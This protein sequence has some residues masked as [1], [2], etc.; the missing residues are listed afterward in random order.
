MGYDPE[1]NARMQETQ[2][3]AGKNYAISLLAGL[4]SAFVLGKIISVMT[5]DRALHGVKVGFAM[6]AILAVWPR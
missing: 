2:M 1:D 6:G 4:V 5:L 3:S